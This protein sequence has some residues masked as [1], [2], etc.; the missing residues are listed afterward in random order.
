MCIIIH[1]YRTNR[2]VR[3][4]KIIKHVDCGKNS[5]IYQ[6]EDKHG[7]Q[8]EVSFSKNHATVFGSKEA[9][10]K[11]FKL[12]ADYEAHITKEKTR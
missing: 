11:L 7:G 3:H 2:K 8:F 9:I 10:L 12:E 1:Y 5:Q 4:M 6:M